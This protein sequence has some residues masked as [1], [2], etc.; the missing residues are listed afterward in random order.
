[1]GFVEPNIVAA[2]IWFWHC[3]F[4]YLFPL[5][6]EDQHSI[7]EASTYVYQVKCFELF[8][9]FFFLCCSWQ[10]LLDEEGGALGNVLCVVVAK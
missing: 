1:M 2:H 8:P 5:K 10:P 7:P 6:R 3:S 4:V 9:S